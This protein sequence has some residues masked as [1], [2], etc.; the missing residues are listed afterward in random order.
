VA[1]NEGFGSQFGETVYTSEVN[2]NRKIKSDEQVAIN[3]KLFSW[4]GWG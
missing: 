3:E 4:S 1:P 2:G